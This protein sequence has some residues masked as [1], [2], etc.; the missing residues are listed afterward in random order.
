[1]DYTYTAYT[2]DRKLVK[3][4]LNAATT[5]MATR[6]LSYGGYQVVN[7]KPAASFLS[8]GFFSFSGGAGKVSA[9]EV[10]LLSRQLA[11]LLESG[12]DL[13]NSL[14]LLY[15]Q[16]TSKGLQKVLNEIIHDIRSGSS[17]SAALGKHPKAF[18]TMFGM[19]NYWPCWG[20]ESTMGRC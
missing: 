2:K 1:M 9:K 7:L 12:T 13:V 5:E 14:D 15:K 4:K 10:L 17:F 3:G 20:E 18:S 11:L 19:T 6:V 8:G 16:T